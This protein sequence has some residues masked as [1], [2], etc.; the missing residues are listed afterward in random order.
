MIVLDTTVLVYAVGAEHPLR[1]AC[2]N[3][4]QLVG[5]GVLR[6]TTTVEVLQEFAQVRGRRRGRDDAR[7]LASRYVDLFAPLLETK[8]AHLQLGLELWAR[9]R[10]LGCLDAV[11]AAVAQATGSGVI[12]SADV[13]FATVEGIVHVLPDA[14]G[15]D[16]LVQH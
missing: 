1:D 8:T 9:H 3:L 15:I 10:Q 4:L 6:A 7:A 5:D 11:L 12:V 16:Q 13:G 2:R 14:A